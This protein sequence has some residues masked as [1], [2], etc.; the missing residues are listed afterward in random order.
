MNWM[1]CSDLHLVTASEIVRATNW[2]SELLYDTL[3]RIKNDT[4]AVECLSRIAHI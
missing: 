4:C 1:W 3:S 2:R